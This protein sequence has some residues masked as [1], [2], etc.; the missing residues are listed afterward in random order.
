MKIKPVKSY[1]PPSLP[2][3]TDAAPEL[4]KNMPRRWKK[5]AAVAA[6]VGVIGMTAFAGCVIEQ[7]P[8]RPHHGGAGGG[9]DAPDYFVYPTE[10]SIDAFAA[11]ELFRNQLETAE[12]DIKTHYGGS[13]SGP[14]YVVYFTEQDA[15]NYIRAKLEAAGLNF[16]DT[17]PDV[18][19]DLPGFFN[20]DDKLGLDLY[21]GEK[22]VAVSHISY[23]QN[24][25]PFFS[26]GGS[27]LS[28]E[29]LKEF[30]QQLENTT[31]G[32]FYNPGAM[33]GRGSE[34][35]GRGFGEGWFIEV[36]PE[37]T[38]EARQALIDELTVQAQAF[39]EKLTDKGKL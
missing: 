28:N 15:F 13:G 31:V 16:G 5:K 27:N 24:N 10:G 1:T 4:L 25:T 19:V 18:T 6:C 9:S 2:V 39:I 36:T 35:E 8:E 12:L 7:F 26:W 32:I 21:D 22:D 11:V 30:S 33:V 3:L 38:E 23:E 37:R 17:P 14:F 29:I 20:D 34:E